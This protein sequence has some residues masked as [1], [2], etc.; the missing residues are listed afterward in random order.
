[1]NY[2]EM[3]QAMSYLEIK[4]AMDYL[5]I[6][7]LGFKLSLYRQSLVNLMNGERGELGGGRVREE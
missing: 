4:Q 5:E 3:K 7:C 1:M 6:I 2:L